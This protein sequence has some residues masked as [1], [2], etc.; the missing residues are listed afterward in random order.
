MK[1]KVTYSKHADKWFLKADKTVVKM[2]YAWIEKN[3]VDA[4]NPREHGKV[5]VGELS[6]LWRYRVGDYRIICEICDKEVVIQ[7]IEVGHRSKIYN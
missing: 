3:L 2:I 6:G 1:Y 7:I 5:L 4:Q